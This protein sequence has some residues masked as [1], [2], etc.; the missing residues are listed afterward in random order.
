[1]PRGTFNSH[2]MTCDRIS[3]LP[4]KAGLFRQPLGNRTE[5][6]E[7]TMS[8]QGQTREEKGSIHGPGV[9]KCKHC[10]AVGC[11]SNDCTNRNFWAG[12]CLKCGRSTSR[13]SVS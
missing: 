13:E 11:D 2:V 8:C 7:Q 3:D 9:Y 5:S 10:G 1:M 6:K 12:K 4:G